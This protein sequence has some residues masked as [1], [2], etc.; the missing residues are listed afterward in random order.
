MASGTTQQ[1]RPAP[2]WLLVP[3]SGTWL[4]GPFVSIGFSSSALGLIHF[5]SKIPLG[6]MLGLADPVVEDADDCD[7]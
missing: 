1:P 6:G 4:V 7:R 3:A 5:V 2:R